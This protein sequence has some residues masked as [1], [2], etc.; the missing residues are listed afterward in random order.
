MENAYDDKINIE[1]SQLLILMHQL[2]PIKNPPSIAISVYLCQ[3]QYLYLIA[4]SKNFISIIIP[5]MV[6]R[7]TRRTANDDS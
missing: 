7:L 6:V 1:K 5:A 4:T 3:D 2:K